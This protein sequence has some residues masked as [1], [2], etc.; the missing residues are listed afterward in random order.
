MTW[1]TIFLCESNGAGETVTHGLT[2]CVYGSSDA[3]NL[4]ASSATI[5]AGNNSY[6]KYWRVEYD[7]EGD[8]TQ[9]EDIKMWR[10]G[11][12]GTGTTHD[13][14]FSVTYATPSTSAMTGSSFPTLEPTSANVEVGGVAGDPL[15]TAGSHSDYIKSQIKT[16]ASDTGA[17][18]FYICIAWF[19]T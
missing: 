3:A 18:T 4:T 12:L 11:S 9:I 8:S 19:E 13:V 14:D 16:G 17:T 5:D 2:N 15:T 7:A 6:E 10:V 1:G